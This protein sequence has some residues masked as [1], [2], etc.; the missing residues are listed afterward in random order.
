M[1]DER[2]Q[3]AAVHDVDLI[4][5]GRFAKRNVERLPRVPVKARATD[6]G[7]RYATRRRFA[8]TCT[9]LNGRSASRPKVAVNSTKAGSAW[10]RTAGPTR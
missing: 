4:S 5:F 3:N 6:P 1:D 10:S 2:S 9:G 7:E 8:V